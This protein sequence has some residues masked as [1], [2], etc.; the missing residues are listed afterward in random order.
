MARNRG[1]IIDIDV[2]GFNAALLEMLSQTRRSSK[3]VI[4][5]QAKGVIRNVIR[6]TPPG[7]SSGASLGAARK[8]GR[9]KVA[10][11]IHKVLLGVPLKQAEAIDIGSIKAAHKKARKNGQVGESGNRLRV[12][13]TMLNEYIRRQQTKVGRLAAGWRAAAAKFG[14]PLP[15]WI[16]SH[17]TPSLVKVTATSTSFG[18]KATNRS[19]YAQ[20]VRTLERQ[21][22]HAV[23][24][25][26]GAMRKRIASYVAKNARAANFKAGKT[27][28]ASL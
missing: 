17:S 20:S 10:A 19:P 4:A 12:P 23:H 14:V 25:Q 27:A 28:G 8:S 1:Q 6:V 5:E 26:G 18:M 16:A 24:A 13:K 3:E 9:T 21:V 7:R 11:D 22:R 15:P 2:G